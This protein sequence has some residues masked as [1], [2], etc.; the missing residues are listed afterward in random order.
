MARL[1]DREGTTVGLRDAVLVATFSDGLERRNECAALKVR[2]LTE[3]DDDSGRLLVRRNKTDQTGEGA[4]LY[5]GSPTVRRIR[6]WLETA[7]FREGAMFRRIRKGSRGGEQALAARSIRH[8]IAARAAAAA[9]LEGRFSAH[10]LRV[11]G[12]QSLVKRGATLPEAK[13]AGRW[14]TPRMVVHYAR[15]ATAGRRAVARL[16]YGV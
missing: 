7:A 14:Q 8:I 1:C 9:G 11:G 12:A 4:V 16:R 6:V 15:G 13:L 5:L 2:D 3:N 10:S